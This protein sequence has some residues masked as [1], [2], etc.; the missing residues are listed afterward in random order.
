MSEYEVKLSILTISATL[1]ALS[2]MIGFCTGGFI[3][4]PCGKKLTMFVFNLCAFAC[5]IISATGR[6]KWFLYISYSLQGFFGALAYNCV[7]KIK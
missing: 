7:G 3:S 1:Y 4:D 6:T 5:W 2:T